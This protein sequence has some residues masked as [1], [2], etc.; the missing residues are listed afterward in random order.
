M[1]K[2]LHPVEIETFYVLPAV[3]RQLALS[4]KQLGIPQKDIA[5]KLHLQAAAVSQYLSDKRGKQCDLSEDIIKEAGISAKRI[6]NDASL[7]YEMNRLLQL[8]R[9][10]SLICNIHKQFSAVPHGCAVSTAC[11]D[12]VSQ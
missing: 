5:T 8:I 3:R 4:M 2:M 11:C 12:E 1:A 7:M 10:S 6:T 9:S